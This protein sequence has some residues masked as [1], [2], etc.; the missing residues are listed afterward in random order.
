M[1]AASLEAVNDILGDLEKR[2]EDEM[3]SKRCSHQ[4]FLSATSSS[5]VVPSK[6]SRSLV[7]DVHTPPPATSND[8]LDGGD[9]DL[10]EAEVEEEEVVL[11]KKSMTSSLSSNSNS[12]PNPNSSNPKPSKHSVNR[13][14]RCYSDSG[15][16]GSPKR[17]RK[18]GIFSMY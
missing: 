14:Q 3:K 18:V 15:S 8:D 10:E 4:R 12:N 2:E 5:R 9:E 1:S 13:F 16:P 17:K 7:V 11:R 6:T